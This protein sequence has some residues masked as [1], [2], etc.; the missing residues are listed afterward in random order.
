MVQMMA[1]MFLISEIHTR[2][3]SRCSPCW[4]SR[5]LMSWRIT[6]FSSSCPVRR[7]CGRS[8]SC[9]LMTTYIKTI[10]RAAGYHFPFGCSGSPRPD[11]RLEAGE[12]NIIPY[13][14]FQGRVLLGPCA[15]VHRQVQSTVKHIQDTG[16]YR[17]EYSW[18]GKTYVQEAAPGWE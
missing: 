12:A 18:P 7:R 1:Y 2:T 9:W 3:P 11:G 13:I 10:L 8:Q 5:K 6:L 4:K 14:I 16:T 15:G 17:P